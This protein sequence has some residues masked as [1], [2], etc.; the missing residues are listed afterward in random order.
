M[1]Y[2]HKVKQQK[3]LRQIWETILLCNFFLS[4]LIQL[5]NNSNIK[6]RYYKNIT[7]QFLYHSSSNSKSIPENLAT[8]HEYY[9]F[10]QK[11]ISQLFVT[12][13]III[14]I[15]NGILYKNTGSTNYL[16]DYC[17]LLDVTYQ[18]NNFTVVNKMLMKFLCYFQILGIC[19][20]QNLRADIFAQK[21]KW[22]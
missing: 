3:I 6:T 17:P 22:H 18:L 1:I 16:Q 4:D 8:V 19:F 20:A 7:R 10:I 21:A 11:H 14:I 5:L 2:F 12:I 15:T 9:T 13:I